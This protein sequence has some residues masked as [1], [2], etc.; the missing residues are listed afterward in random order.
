MFE[1]TDKPQIYALPPGADF[2]AVMAETLRDRYAAQ[3][4]EAFARVR[5]LVNARRMQRRLKDLLSDGTPRL[6]PQIGLVTEL[7]VLLP[8]ADLPLPDST[9][10]RRLEL[11]SLVSALI[12]TDPTLAPRAAIAD[13]AQSLNQ[14]LEELGSEGVTP[15]DI[16]KLD[17][18]DETGHWARSLRFLDI[19]GQYVEA[20]QDALLNPEQRRRRLVGLLAKA[21]ST[22]PPKDPIVIAG[23]TG[24]RGT[25]LDLMEHVARLPAGV[26][27]LPG[28]DFNLPDTVWSTLQQSRAHED[29]PQYRYARLLSRLGLTRDAVIPLA[30]PVPSDSRNALISLSLRPAPVTHQWM[31]EGPGLD[32]MRDTTAG[33]TLIQAPDQREEALA[34][35]IAIREALENGKVAALISPDRTL[36]RRVSAA[37]SR[38]DIT[39]DDSS[40]QPLSLTAPGR[41][42]RQIG[43]MIGKPV[44]TAELVALLKHPLTHS[45]G[46]ARKT[47]TLIANALELYL[48][49]KGVA[50]VDGDVLERF[51]LDADEETKR[52][53]DW[54]SDLTA[55]LA[56]TPEPRLKTNLSHHI[57]LAERLASGPRDGTGELWEKGPG[58]EATKLVESFRREESFDQPLGFADYLRY[59]EQALMGE[60]YRN[61]D[62]SRS[63][64]MIWG[65]LEARVQGADFV[66][67]GG[68]NEGIWPEQPA[69][70]PWLN[71]RMRTKLGLLLPERQIGL[72]AHDYQQAI[73]SQTVV[74][75]RA[76]RNADSET[77]PSRWLNRLMNLMKGV[78]ER[79]GPEA[80]ASMVARGDRLLDIGRALERPVAEVPAAARPCPAP[81]SD[82]RPKSY[83]ITELSK[84]V[85]DPYAI[86]ARRILRIRPL[87]PLVPEADARLRGILFHDILEQFSKSTDTDGDALHAALLDVAHD[88]LEDLPWPAT[89]LQWRAQIDA[90]ADRLV[91]NELRRRGEG[92]LIA[93]ETKGKMTVPGTDFV[94]DGRADR[95]DRNRET[96]GLVIFDYKTTIPKEAVIRAFDPQL[97]VEAVM[98]EN[99]CFENVPAAPVERIE[100]IALSRNADDAQYHIGGTGK[101]SFDIVSIPA[102]LAELLTSFAQ[103]ERGYAARRAV[104]TQ[105]FE[106]DYDHLARYGEWDDSADPDPE[107]IGHG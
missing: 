81:P 91:Q 72:S 71:R 88:T 33:L 99:G 7:D 43:R 101:K 104:Q 10:R 73:G 23:S 18:L 56:A 79:H 77:V 5:V 6:L 9:L 64:V 92:D 67:L 74:L 58:R 19:I 41:F 35:A 4:P 82:V 30:G 28:F 29:H 76:Q 44:P 25:T 42:L 14:L 40:G 21:W 75:A 12:D 53:C 51:A 87:N 59:F 26:L 102:Q 90:I 22:H 31:T 89:G 27:V 17:P 63:D 32:D 103:T 66:V 50:V 96:G 20:T 62:D 61:S 38:W 69:A 24:S 60:S 47:H 34:I 65:T 98:A 2:P 78:P 93:A 84:L 48:R 107:R 86:Y 13:L 49:Q 3:P 16:G 68:L 80:L 105:T 39:A 46:D 1:T 70:D 83:A 57:G 8:G 45:G 97:L 55:T 54:L 11:G 106:G 37:L 100:Y 36:G 52:W 85:R 95:I 15:E 94:L